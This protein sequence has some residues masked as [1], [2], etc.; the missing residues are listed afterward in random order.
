MYEVEDTENVRR[1]TVRLEAIQDYAI[2]ISASLMILGWLM[3]SII[4]FKLIYL[5][6]LVLL[7][8]SFFMKPRLIA[9]RYYR[10]EMLEAAKKAMERA[11]QL[12]AASNE[13]MLKKQFK[14]GQWI[15]STDRKRL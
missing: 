7:I 6:P 9:V 12:T 10:K 5:I 8:G 15:R 13:D 3:S 11:D 14:N 2:K 4:G 1:L